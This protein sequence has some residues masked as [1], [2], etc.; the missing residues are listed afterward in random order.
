MDLQYPMTRNEYEEH[1][2]WRSDEDQI[3]HDTAFSMWVDENKID[4][5]HKFSST[6]VIPKFRK[7]MLEGERPNWVGKVQYYAYSFF[8]LSW[9]YR[10]YLEAMYGNVTRRSVKMVW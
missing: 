9:P 8:L 4:K 3:K 1:W 10:V 5:L 7:Y 2:M 6:Y